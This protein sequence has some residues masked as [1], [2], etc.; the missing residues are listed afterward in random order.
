MTSN[1][2]SRVYLQLPAYTAQD[3]AR[4]NAQRR[5]LA[6]FEPYLEDR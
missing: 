5:S 1:R 2:T 4:L 3:L 6:R